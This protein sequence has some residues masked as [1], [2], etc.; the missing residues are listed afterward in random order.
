MENQELLKYIED[1]QDQGYSK[2]EIRDTLMNVGWRIDDIKDAFKII[3]ASNQAKFFE[4]GSKKQK[5]II[6]IGIAVVV[7]LFG[8]SAFGGYYYYQT[9][10][11]RAIKK[12]QENLDHV[13]SVKYDVISSIIIKTD[14]YGES[15]DISATAQG[16][17][18][19]IDKEDIK[20]YVDLNANVGMDV[21][22]S[23]EEGIDILT[24]NSVFTASF[25]TV[26]NISYVKLDIPIMISSFLP[27]YDNIINN[28]WVEFDQQSLKEFTNDSVG[29]DISISSQL[30]DEAISKLKEYNLLEAEYVKSEEI[31]GVETRRLSFSVNED[32]LARFFDDNY[33]SGENSIET[34]DA[35]KEMTGEC[36]IGKKDGF[37]YRIDV[38]MDLD[39]G[40][41][42]GMITMKAEFSDFNK[43]INVTVPVETKKYEELSIKN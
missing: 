5:F 3:N 12:A 24:Q 18:D 13:E 15:G 26:N 11:T 25:K 19:K 23:T 41:S 30:F 31:N 14:E 1:A 2:E 7:F 36:W 43:P 28:Q 40:E 38:N 37:I 42:E 4:A 6:F 9:I 35:M 22:T 39:Y 21:E 29:I 27:F 10:P 8:S 20:K 17:F 33:E 34:F 16:A 32:E